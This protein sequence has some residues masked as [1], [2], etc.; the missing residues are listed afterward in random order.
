[1]IGV[2]VT[3]S[4]ASSS[5]AGD[6]SSTVWPSDSS[7]RGRVLDGRDALRV[8]GATSSGAARAHRRCAACPGSAPT[9]SAYGARGRRRG[10]PVADHVALQ[11]VEDGRAVAHAARRRRGASTR[12]AHDS[13][14]SGPSE[15][16]PR[17]GFKPKS[18]HMLAGM[19]IE[20]PPSPRVR[21]RHHAARDRGRRCRRSNRRTSARCSTGCA[22]VRTPAARSSA[23]AR[24]RACSSCRRSRSPRASS[25][26]TR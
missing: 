11:H 26:A 6:A 8:D 21:D 5:A 14:S 2:N 16:R 15:M 19:R 17:D 18:P 25:F 13:A 1:M 10:V 7:R 23:S 9:S 12:P 24:T 20:P 22:S 3:S 4:D